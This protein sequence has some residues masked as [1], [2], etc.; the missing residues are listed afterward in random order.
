MVRN[1]TPWRAVA[2][3]ESEAGILRRYEGPALCWPS[4]L[5]RMEN[6]WMCGVANYCC[7]GI[8]VASDHGSH[9][10]GRITSD[11]QLLADRCVD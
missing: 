1:R 7:A 3:L 5:R 10:Y 4:Y 11:D 9:T 2:R 6:D 8:D